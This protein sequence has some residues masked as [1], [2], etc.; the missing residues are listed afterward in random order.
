MDNTAGKFFNDPQ[1][2]DNLTGM[3]A[4]ARLLLNDFRQNPKKFLRVKFSIF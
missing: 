3:L 1:F 2:Y 4:D